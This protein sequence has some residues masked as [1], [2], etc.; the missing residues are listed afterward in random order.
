MRGVSVRGFRL[1]LVLAAALAISSSPRS[2][3]AVNYMVQLNP[4][5]TVVQAA[6]PV[7]D[8]RDT[9]TSKAEAVAAARLSARTYAVALAPFALLTTTESAA[10]TAAATYD[11]I[12][13]TG[14]AAM[15]LATLRIPFSALLVDR[16][17]TWGGT[18]AFH[19]NTTNTS[20]FRAQFGASSAQVDFRIL[21]YEGIKDISVQTSAVGATATPVLRQTTFFG[22]LV[23]FLGSSGGL[24]V[25]AGAEGFEAFQMYGDL[26]LSAVVPTN[27]TLTLD[28]RLRLESDTQANFIAPSYSLLAAPLGL[29]LPR[30]V[31]VFELPAGF[32]ANSQSLELV[33]NLVVPEPSSRAAY[34][35]AVI[36]LILLVQGRTRGRIARTNAA[37]AKSSAGS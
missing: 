11:D 20:T 23:I 28:L 37:I 12:V 26:I 29:G 4:P 17:E 22:D 5:G 14:P 32:T 31:P 36:T 7:S 2:A 35:A 6:A 33:N 10:A 9:P 8:S 1:W 34:P 16:H 19:S 13:I 15:V 27:T 18:F 30:G 3:R 24:G 25:F 21:P